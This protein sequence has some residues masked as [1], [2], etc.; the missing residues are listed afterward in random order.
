[1]VAQ[2]DC[3]FRPSRSISQERYAMRRFLST[4]SLESVVVS[5]A[6][7]QRR[8]LGQSEGVFLANDLDS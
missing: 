5:Q 2:L 3:S 8:V 1:M 4:K 7:K 6:V